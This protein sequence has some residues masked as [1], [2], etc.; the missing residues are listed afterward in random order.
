M[1]KQE[2]NK[3]K[4]DRMAYTKDSLPSLFS[5]LAILANV[6]FFVSIYKTN[7][8]SYYT[9]IIGIS[10]IVNLLF[11]LASF[12]CSEGVK[13]YK[14]QYGVALIV[15]GAIELLRILYFPLVGISNIDSTT[16][17]PIMDTNQFI[18][19]T[20]YLLC[21]AGFCISGG[22][23]SICNSNKLEKYLNSK[24]VKK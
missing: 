14:K 16:G 9:Y 1:T 3:I 17:L 7:L 15:L 2:R 12:L 6:F 13:A 24:K 18:F 4:I 11:M 21:A 22:I 20:G 19:T 23:I 10:V 8:K 5:Y